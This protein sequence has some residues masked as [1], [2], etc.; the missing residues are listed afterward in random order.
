MLGVH[1]ERPG[2][3]HDHQTHI[4]ARKNVGE[5]CHGVGNKVKRVLGPTA[6]GVDHGVK[7]LELLT[8]NRQGVALEEVLRLRAVIASGDGSDVKPAT[9]GLRHDEAAHATICCDDSDLLG[10]VLAHGDPLS[11]LA[12]ARRRRPFDTCNITGI[13]AYLKVSTLK[14]CKYLRVTIGGYQACRKTKSCSA[15]CRHAR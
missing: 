2:A 3:A 6:H 9:H 14:C 10:V 8:N 4:G 5:M 13:S 15:D 7:P 11:V 12:S 1:A